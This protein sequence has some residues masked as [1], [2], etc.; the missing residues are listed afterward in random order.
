MEASDI[1]K[2]K[3]L[4]CTDC[5]SGIIELLLQSTVALSENHIKENLTDSFDRTTFYRSFKTLVE[6]NVI[7]KILVEDETKYMLTPEEEKKGDSHA[8]FY[9]LKCAKVFC[10]SKTNLTAFKLPEGFSAENIEVIIKGKCKYCN[11]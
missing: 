2:N 6:H 11:E 4:K 5:R 8:H 1:L 3:N 10:I 7:H 9:C